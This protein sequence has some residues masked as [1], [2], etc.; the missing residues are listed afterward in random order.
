M[1]WRESSAYGG[2]SL[3][4]GD[5]QQVRQQGFLGR[6]ARRQQLAAGAGPKASQLLLPGLWHAHGDFEEAP[7][8]YERGRMDGQL[9]P[10]GRIL[11]AWD[12]PRASEI[13]HV[14]GCGG[15]AAIRGPPDGLERIAL[16]VHE[17]H[18]GSDLL[19]QIPQTRV[20][21]A[22]AFERPGGKA[23]GRGRLG[24][25]GATLPGRLPTGRAYMSDVAKADAVCREGNKG[26]G[27]DYQSSQVL[28]G[29]YAESEAPGS[30]YRLS[31]KHLLRDRRQAGQDTRRSQDNALHECRQKTVGHRAC[32][33]AADGSGTVS[34]P[35]SA[36]SQIS[37][38]GAARLS[39]YSTVVEQ[40]SQA[41]KPS[42]A[43][44]GLVD[45][46][47]QQVERS[48]HLAITL[49]G[50]PAHRRVND[51]LGRGGEQY[52]ARTRVLAERS[53]TLPHHAPGTQG[54]PLLHREFRERTARARRATLVRQSGGG[55]NLDQRDEPFTGD[56]E[57]AAEAVAPAGPHRYLAAGAIHTVRGKRVGRRVIPTR[58]RRRLDAG[59]E[60][61]RGTRA[62]L[63][64]A[65][66]GE[67]R[68]CEQHPP[69]KVQLRI[70]L[71]RFGRR[72]RDDSSLGR[73][74]QL[75]QPPVGDAGQSGA[76]AAIGRCS[77]HSGRSFLAECNLVERTPRPGLRNYSLAGVSRIV[78]SR[79]AGIFRQRRSTWLG[80]RDLPNPWAPAYVIR[81]QTAALYERWAN[82]SPEEQARQRAKV[83]ENDA[84]VLV[85]DGE[86]RRLLKSKYALKPMEDS[87]KVPWAA[88]LEAKYKDLAASSVEGR[89][90]VDLLQTG[91]APNTATSYDS[92]LA[93]FLFYCDSAGLSAMPASQSTVLRY[94]GHMAREGTVHVDNVQPYLS[95]INTAHVSVGLDPPAIG[96]SVSQA[97]KGWRQRLRHVGPIDDKRVPLP[98]GV[99]KL[100]LRLGNQLVRKGDYK[101][102]AAAYGLLRDVVAVITTYLFFGRS[103]TGFA[104]RNDGF[105][106]VQIHG[107]DL[108]FYM[109]NVKGTAVGERKKTLVYPLEGAGKRT[110]VRVLST[111]LRSAPCTKGDLWRLPQDGNTWNAT[112]IDSMLTRLLTK[113]NISPPEGYTYSSHSLR[114]GAASAAFAVGVD[115]T[116]ICFCGGWAV[117][118]HAVY[119]YIDLTW[120]ESAD[121]DFFF[122]HLRHNRQQFLGNV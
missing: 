92:K 109:R 116:R 82:L 85:T 13:L 67:V 30:G 88:A 50:K 31:A 86:K 78:P 15:D 6:E 90:A 113:L 64:T 3:G 25:D 61:L 2:R 8:S 12:C 40:Q 73:R 110:L 36:S 57:G 74:K 20:A 5:L 27:A 9:R 68:H 79:S 77:G 117:G 60:I 75:C 47:A 62:A 112:V 87:T 24:G 32:G 51:G 22:R 53:A 122:G 35:R 29:A 80:R 66:D 108:M 38:S 94:I 97:R 10:Q 102:D 41:V 19:P 16:G 111:F 106:D 63:R 4:A 34:V 118:S 99:M 105:P 70:P 46:D 44:P 1:A 103:D 84:V 120:Q 33:G 69:A 28:L 43:R 119:R 114:S 11:R 23:A 17:V 26:V 21:A 56:D 93:K 121:A 65:H 52:I 100:I 42:P 98:P 7:K 81:R 49:L 37:P 83:A 71:A 54:C 14:R 58:E 45:Q 55:A 59:L 48:R 104:A 107:T 39:L 89:T 101:H 91:L 76:E 72:E 96:P 95:C 115:I 18:T